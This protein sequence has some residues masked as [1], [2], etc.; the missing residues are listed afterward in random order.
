MGRPIA[1][2]QIKV[3][4]QKFIW[5]ILNHNNYVVGT[6]K[7]RLNE[8]V[9]LRAQN[10]WISKL[11]DI[12]TDGYKNKHNFT[13]KKFTYLDLCPYYFIMCNLINLKS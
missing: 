8:T 12:K 6:Q 13:L 7:N 10:I 2:L 4:N 1:G 3:C 5:L 9:L 11:M